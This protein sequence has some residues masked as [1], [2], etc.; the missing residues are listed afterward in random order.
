MAGKTNTITAQIIPRNGT[1]ASWAQHNPVLLAGELGVETDTGKFKFG[2]GVNAWNQLPYSGGSSSG[3]G[4]S[5]STTPRPVNASSLGY[6]CL[7]DYWVEP[8]Y[9]D[10]NGDETPCNCDMYVHHRSNSAAQKLG[11]TGSEFHCGPTYPVN[12]IT[13][14]TEVS[15]SAHLYICDFPTYAKL[16]VI[17][18]VSKNYNIDFAVNGTNEL[19]LPPNKPWEVLVT[20][21]QQRKTVNGVTFNINSLYRL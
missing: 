15:D 17:N 1:A 5:G 4:G 3:S 6:D 8:W 7:D 9:I 16:I 19:E 20:G 10:E 2:N 11:Y 18:S 13:I 12:V 14:E 21:V